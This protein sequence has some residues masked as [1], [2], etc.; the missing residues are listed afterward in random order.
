MEER[1]PQ[2]R[3]IHAVRVRDFH[4][5]G[6]QGGGRI[7]VKFSITVP[8]HGHAEFSMYADP[9]NPRPEVHVSDPSASYKLLLTSDVVVQD[10]KEARAI[11]YWVL[12]REY[13]KQMDGLLGE[14]GSL[15]RKP[16][17][18]S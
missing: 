12:L 5:Y 4:H 9:V 10:E 6:V 16:T 7:M 14:F 2:W 11:P 15:L 17:L 18:S 8:A 13:L 1:V 3:L